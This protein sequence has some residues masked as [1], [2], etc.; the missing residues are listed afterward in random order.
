MSSASTCPPGQCRGGVRGREIAV[1][2]PLER[3]QPVLPM[4]SRIPERQAH[5]YARHGVTCL[6]AALEVA[7][8][9][10]TDAWS[11]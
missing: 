6:F 7:T 2:G 10:V 11:S 4:R 1:S 5:D 3:T 8:G 9:T